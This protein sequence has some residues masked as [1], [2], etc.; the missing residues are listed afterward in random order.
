MRCPEEECLVYATLQRDRADWKTHKARDECGKA[1][2]RAAAAVCDVC[3]CF[4]SPRE[5]PLEYIAAAHARLV[6]LLCT[7]IHARRGLLFFFSWGGGTMHPCTRVE[8]D[9]RAA[10]W[11][12]CFI[13]IFGSAHHLS[14][15]ESLGA[16]GAW[17]QCVFFFV[18]AVAHVDVIR[19]WEERII[20]EELSMR[21]V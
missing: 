8:S 21:I 12:C 7:H 3:L 13:G 16:A 11:G 1:P 10:R 14:G 19:V 15:L 20:G 18:G 4:S 9:R 5:L 17:T 6:H 2:P